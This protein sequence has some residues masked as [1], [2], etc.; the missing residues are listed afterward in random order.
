VNLRIYGN[1]IFNT[2]KKLTEYDEKS[3]LFN[4]YLKKVVNNL[5]LAT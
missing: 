3:K 2:G 5:T 1:L 4:D